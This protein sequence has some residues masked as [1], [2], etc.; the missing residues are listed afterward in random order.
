MLLVFEGGDTFF[1]GVWNTWNVSNNAVKRFQGTSFI[2]NF[3][4]NMEYLDN[5]AVGV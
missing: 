5:N 3:T 1:Q 4:K 2:G